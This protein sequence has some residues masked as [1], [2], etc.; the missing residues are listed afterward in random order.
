MVRSLA[1]IT[2]CEQVATDMPIERTT[3]EV[4]HGVPIIY[5]PNALRSLPRECRLAIL[6]HEAAHIALRHWKSS[7]YFR[8]LLMERA[9]LLAPSLFI[10][11]RATQELDADR[12]SIQY[13]SRLGFANGV[14]VLAQT[15]SRLEPSSMGRLRLQSL[16]T[17]SASLRAEALWTGE[18]HGHEQGGQRG[19]GC[20]RRSDE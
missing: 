9:T 13:L 1:G 3:V 7:E 8:T 17:D 4:F 10:A 14:E 18:I 12:M 5:L 6:A 15:L 11:L 19:G 16:A 20:D 2:E